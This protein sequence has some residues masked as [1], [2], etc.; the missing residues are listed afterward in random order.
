MKN[1]K[2]KAYLGFSVRSR[3]IVFG[4]DDVE[5]QRRDVYLLLADET[6]GTSS[7]KT[8]IKMQEQL[9]CPMLLLEKGALGELLARPAVKAVAIKEK[10][11]AAAILSE[12]EGE[13]QFKLYSGGNN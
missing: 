13:P 11:L 10:N 1:G 8:M 4:V 3:K 7:L 5:K 9:S 6:L 2:I 12:A